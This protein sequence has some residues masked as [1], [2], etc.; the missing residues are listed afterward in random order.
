MQREESAKQ[1]FDALKEKHN[2]PSRASTFPLLTP[3]QHLTNP[4][5]RDFK[6]H[7]ARSIGWTAKRRKATT[8]EKVQYK[9]TRRVCLNERNRRAVRYRRAHHTLLI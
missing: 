4:C 3:D 2:G 8:V 6:K 1:A 9:H 7:V 5:F